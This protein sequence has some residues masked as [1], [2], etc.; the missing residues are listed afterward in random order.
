M[1]AASEATKNS[2]GWGRPSSDINAR[3]WVRMILGLMIGGARRP[4]EDAV[5]ETENRVR[6]RIES[7]EGINKL[8]GVGNL[9][10]SLLA[11]EFNVNKIDLELLVGLHADQERRTAAG[12]YDFIGIVLRLE[13][14]GEGALELLENGFDKLC[15]GDT[16]VWLRVVDIFR[17]DGNGL[18]V[19]LALKLVTAVLENEAKGGG[20]GDDTV[21]H[22]DEIAGGI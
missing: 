5:L 22:D 16:L 10:I 21:V 12:D 7:L 11:S 18:R 19:G 3:D 9:L 13:D 8:T 14:K 6:K 17:K 2:M 1:A 20:I 15:E 4:P